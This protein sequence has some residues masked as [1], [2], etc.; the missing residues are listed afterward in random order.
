[1]MTA[2]AKEMYPIGG[3]RF[4]SKAPGDTSLLLSEQVGRASSTLRIVSSQNHLSEPGTLPNR[5][6]GTKPTS[7]QFILPQWFFEFVRPLLGGLW[8]VLFKIRF[9][10]IEHIP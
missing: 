9:T 10:G 5:R 1:M 7:Q 6:A 8:R 2:W 3:L 4:M